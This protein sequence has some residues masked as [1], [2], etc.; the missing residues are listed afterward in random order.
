[1][2][3]AIPA[4]AL[5]AGVWA[6]WA[7]PTR[8][9]DQEAVGKAVER[10]VA[11]LRTMQGDNGKWTHPEIGATALAGLTLLEC[12]VPAD[13]KAV[14]KAADA[15]RAAS[16]TCTHTYSI[17]LSILFLDRLGD[18]LDVPLIESLT[19]RLLAG[20]SVAGGWSYDC[21]PIGADEQRRLTT[22]VRERTEL[23]GRR[24]LPKPGA[25]K[26]TARD[27][28]P[29]IQEQLAVLSRRIAPAVQ[30][31]GDNSNTQFATLA[32]WVARRYGL[33]VE[34]ALQA[35][36]LRFRT[37]QGR[38][39]GWPYMSM[40]R[41][42][43][44][45]PGAPTPG[46]PSS[47][48]MTCAGLLGLAVV[49]GATAE[50]VRER[51]PRGKPLAIDKDE[52][53]TRGLLALSTA[54]DHPASERKAAP[55]Q[56]GGKD[57]YFLWSL[58]RVCVI[59]DLDTL[60]K[61]DW[62]AWGAEILLASQA[63]DG[64]WRGLYAEHGADT[65]FAL[66]FL[67]RS[68]L[69]RDLTANIKG[70]LT[71][72]QLREL[73]GGGVGGAGL[74]AGPRPKL[75]PG[76]QGKDAKHEPEQA[77]PSEKLA[78]IPDKAPPA[79]RPPADGA[80]ARLADELVKA[81][82]DQQAT[83]LQKLRD[84]KGVENTEALTFAIPRLEGE[85]RKNAR[86]ALAYRLARLKPETLTNYLKDEEKEIRRAAALACAMRSLKSHIPHLIPLMRD[87]ETDVSRA[88]HAALKDLSGG[89]AGPTAEDWEAWWKKQGKD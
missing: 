49:H 81:A 78:P 3:K 15:V 28:S 6:V 18:P 31:N 85:A 22:K 37:S 35:I 79:D 9:V 8:A 87:R 70:K 24:E 64:S 82:P 59:L 65:C 61:K 89:D 72:A 20:Q 80:S 5:A 38:E 50:A 39:G 55:P 7:V 67:K 17:S 83:L 68:N 34:N 47:A 21:P 73:R 71:D 51:K 32:L 2:R 10:G 66:L 33:P 4:L 30:S 44:L 14:V 88:A 62:Y 42:A 52:V 84:T 29:E 23:V 36:D 1:M 19:V 16:V 75:D 57:F 40:T 43:G 25:E 45:P 12:D 63:G 41:P 26:R 86:E 11:A 76:I 77:R 13:D 58:E 74:K 48:T 60:D 56:A 46:M 53:M 54:V 27:L 69:A